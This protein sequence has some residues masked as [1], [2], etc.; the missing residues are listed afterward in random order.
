[1]N[2]TCQKTVRIVGHS[3]KHNQK[4]ENNIDRFKKNRLEPLFFTTI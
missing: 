2:D 3:D 4:K 1:M